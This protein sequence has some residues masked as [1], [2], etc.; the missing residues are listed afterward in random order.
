MT[1]LALRQDSPVAGL[2]E[3]LETA[4]FAEGPCPQPLSFPVV[5][6]V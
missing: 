1:K 3:G 5:T 6:Q 4:T 2:S